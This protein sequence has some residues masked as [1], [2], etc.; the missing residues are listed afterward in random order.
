MADS[1]LNLIFEGQ[2]TDLIEALSNIQDRLES[3][4]G[5]FQD[6][7]KTQDKVFTDL[8]KQVKKTDDTFKK[9]ND[10]IGKAVSKSKDLESQNRNTIGSIQDYIKNETELGGRIGT[11][12]TSLNKKIGVLKGVV[13]GFNNGSKAAR[14]FKVALAST[15]V[16]LLVIALGS[17]VTF[18]TTTQRGMDSLTKVTRPLQVIMQRLVG[19]V[20]DFG[21]ALFDS[22][23][24]GVK[25]PIGSLKSLGKTIIDSVI[26]PLKNLGVFGK[27]IFK[28][29]SGDIKGGL[30]DIGDVAE[31]TA[32]AVKGIAESVSNTAKQTSDF[33]SESVKQGQQLDKVTKDIE[34]A[35]IALIKRRS[36]L[37]RIT[38]EQ[39]KLAEDVTKTNSERRK[40][41]ER[42]SAAQSELL[43]LEENLIDK[44]ISKLKLQ[45]SFNDTSREDEREL[46]E[47]VARRNEV[48]TASI[49]QQTTL[50]NKLN[51]INNEAAAKR[52]AVQDAEAKRLEEINAK[53]KEQE[54][55]LKSQIDEL[56]NQV[57]GAEL[58]SASELE[59]LEIQRARAIAQIELMKSEIEASAASLGKTVDI[60]DDIKVLIDNVEREYALGVK[61]LEEQRKKAEDEANKL[62]IEKTKEQI[63][64]DFKA[65]IEAAELTSENKKAIALKEITDEDELQKALNKI[66]LEG[67]IAR[68][69]IE[70]AFAQDGSANQIRI[71][72]QITQLQ[73]ELDGINLG[74]VKK[75]FNSID[76]VIQDTFGLDSEQ[77]GLLKEAFTESIDLVNELYDARIQRQQ[78]LVDSIDSEIEAQE[79]LVDKQAELAEKGKANN[80]KTEQDK[81]TKLQK[82]RDEAEKKRRKAELQK[83]K[84][85]LA[86]NAAQTIS[87]LTLAVAK[88]ISAESNK[89]LLGIVTAA[90]GIAALFA[91]FSQ[92]KSVAAESA[93]IEALYD[94]GKIASHHSDDRY[95]KGLSVVDENGNVVNRV[96]GGEWVVNNKSSKANDRFITR[97]NDGEFDNIDLNDLFNNRINQNGQAVSDFQNT[98]YIIG[99]SKSSM[100]YKKLDAIYSKNIDKLISSQSEKT[101]IIPANEDYTIITIKDGNKKVTRVNQ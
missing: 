55:L 76:E 65:Q 26:A 9:T 70:K 82:Q 83:Q 12:I 39:N 73:T 31:N 2:E 30:K 72:N 48:A 8:G 49:E 59:K 28:I 51:T 88:V 13:G 94:G 37:N 81:L 5:D 52:K 6:L 75:S 4:E 41:A 78:E 33:I 100:D 3:M 63:E 79:K 99:E 1:R 56:N 98:Q 14:I 101:M 64:A 92:F 71:G 62:A 29:L 86:I 42:A 16:G 66:K 23:V 69:E 77:F 87:E 19:V 54:D 74:D 40:A 17:L 20:Q 7:Q 80:L 21:G 36:E 58:D 15:G 34:K 44:N 47:L 11:T 35:E 53:I 24:K 91:L 60:S 45:Q 18:L 27:G 50:Q 90:A 10:T 22:I 46:A 85:N 43:A 57:D 97:I 61:K 89:G 68:L 25:D 95:G 32:N 93:A 84:F 38:K 67:E 96:G